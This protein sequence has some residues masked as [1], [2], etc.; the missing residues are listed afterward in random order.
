[1]NAEQILDI[2]ERCNAATPGPWKVGR[3]MLNGRVQVDQSELAQ[4]VNPLKWQCATIGREFR[5]TDADFIVTA[6]AALPTLLAEVDRLR[7]ALE[8]VSKIYPTPYVKEICDDALGV[9][10]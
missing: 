4:K 9:T 3:Y 2:A 1:M 5:Q 6:R 10:P 8:R 7:E